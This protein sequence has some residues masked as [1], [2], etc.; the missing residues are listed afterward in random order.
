MGDKRG[1]VKTVFRLDGSVVVS[2]ASTKR[3]VEV[4]RR[5]RVSRQGP[6]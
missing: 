3:Y 5:L 4:E 1:A 2:V 6:D